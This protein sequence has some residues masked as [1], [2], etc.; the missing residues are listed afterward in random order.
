MMSVAASKVEQSV[1][2]RVEQ[3][4]ADHDQTGILLGIQAGD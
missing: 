4:V 3:I 1:Q 2:R